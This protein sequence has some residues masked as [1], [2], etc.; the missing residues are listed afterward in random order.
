MRLAKG[1]CQFPYPRI[2]SYTSISGI[3][4]HGFFVSLCKSQQRTRQCSADFAQLR[5]SAAKGRSQ[6]Q[7]LRFTEVFA[8]GASCKN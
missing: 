6:S 5:K 2:K 4:G 3:G 8:C 1:L 7:P